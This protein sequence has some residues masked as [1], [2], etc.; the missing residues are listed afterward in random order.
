MLVYLYK[1]LPKVEHFTTGLLSIPSLGLVLADIILPRIFFLIGE[2]PLL[3]PFFLHPLIM[4]KVR[5]L[6]TV[7]FLFLKMLV[8][9]FFSDFY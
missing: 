2:Q 1:P 6:K 8:P 4:F 9:L 7:G 3:K 5:V